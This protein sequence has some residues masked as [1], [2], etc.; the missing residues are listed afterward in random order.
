MTENAHACKGWFNIIFFQT[1]NSVALFC[2]NHILMN[3]RKQE[4]KSEMFNTAV[5]SS[6]GKHKIP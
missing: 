5:E 1:A 6:P 3:W 4:I 2:R